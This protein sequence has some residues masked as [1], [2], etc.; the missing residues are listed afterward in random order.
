ML[1]ELRVQPVKSH[2]TS[3]TW[4]NT[5]VAARGGNNEKWLTKKKVEIVTRKNVEKTVRRQLVLEDGRVLD[6]DQPVVTRDT[7]E[8]KEIFET[9]ADEERDNDGGDMNIGDRVTTL[10]TVRDVKEN[11]TKTEAAQNVGTIASRDI[12]RVIKD[13]SK[14]D[15]VLRRPRNSRDLAVTNIPVVVHNSRNHSK[16]TDTEQVKEKSVKRG[17]KMFTERVRT[18]QHEEYESNDNQTSDEGEDFEKIEYEELYQEE[19]KEY[20][21]K[22]EESFIEYF[23]NGQNQDNKFG[24]VKVG[25]GPHFKSVTKQFS[26]NTKS[27]L[28]GAPQRKPLKQSRSWDNDREDKLGNISVSKQHSSSLSDLSRN[29]C[30]RVFIAKVIDETPA[31]RLRNKKKQDINRYIEHRQ[32]ANFSSSGNVITRTNN[33][34]NSSRCSTPTSKEYHFRNCRVKDDRRER[35]MSLDIT[36]KFYYS[37]PE[38]KSKEYCHN[39]FSTLRNQRSYHSNLDIS[40]KPKQIE[41]KIESPT[42]GNLKL[43]PRHYSSSDNLL[44]ERNICTKSLVRK[45]DKFQ[46]IGDICFTTSK[47]I[48]NLQREVV[49]RNERSNSS[50]PTSRKTSGESSRKSSWESLKMSS[51][52]SSRKTSGESSRRPSN[53]RKMSGQLIFTSEKPSRPNLDRIYQTSTLEK[54]FKTSSCTNLSTKVI[55]IDLSCSSIS[56]PFSTPS[57]PSTKYRTRVAVHGSA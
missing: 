19:P 33:S 48:P 51:G 12:A 5:R 25:E 43:V 34:N 24:M 55:P 56:S 28:A 10:K 46:S 1:S 50:A 49:I 47:E 9:D 7:T 20:K 57:S 30:E 40:E 39:Q 44:K 27:S 41:I 29:G 38:T 32:S 26:K 36:N 31:V 22:T 13:R 6:A 15:N 2:L 17:G 16:V 11:V 35:P 53:D 52:T 23:Q 45:S 3:D 4:E 21:T 54:G 42:N 18:E 14:L 8:N 37:G